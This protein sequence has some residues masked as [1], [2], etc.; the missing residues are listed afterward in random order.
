MITSKGERVLELSIS[1][2]II[3]TL[4]K[5]YTRLGRS[6]I[7][8]KEISNHRCEILHNFLDPKLIVRA[9]IISLQYFTFLFMGHNAH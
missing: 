9:L 4:S 3:A 8:F 5:F 1:F 6:I 2:N 7:K